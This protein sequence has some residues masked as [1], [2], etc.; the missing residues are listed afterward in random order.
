MHFRVSRIKQQ[1]S[2][3]KQRLVAE[4]IT[5]H[6]ILTVLRCS[7]KRERGDS[8]HWHDDAFLRGFARKSVTV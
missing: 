8:E 6:N 3:T 5:M 7:E 2:K 4:P 1:S